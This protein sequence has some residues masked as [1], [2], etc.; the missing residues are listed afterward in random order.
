MSKQ[1][2][3]ENLDAVACPSASLCLAVG[4]AGALDISTDPASGVWTR[5]TIDDGRQLTSIA[6]PSTSLCVAADSTG[7]LV[8]STDPTGGSSRWSSALVHDLCT[9]TTPCSVEQIQASDSSGLR[10]VEFSETPGNGPVLT[11]LT[12]TGDVLSW[13]HDGTPRTVTLTP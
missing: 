6:C 3:A 2:V 11:G 10:T 8:T 7:H 1:A 9:A 5:T 12:L 4:A 13:S